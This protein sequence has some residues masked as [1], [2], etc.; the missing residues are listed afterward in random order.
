MLFDRQPEL[1]P[2]ISRA[3]VQSLHYEPALELAKTDPDVSLRFVWQLA[4]D[5][6]RLHKW[7]IALGRG[8]AVERI[9]TLMLDFRGRLMQAGLVNGDDF[10]LPLTQEQIGDHLGLTVVHV[11]RTL[12]K[13]REEGVLTAASGRARIHD[14]EALASY[15]APMQDI[16]ERESK[17][18]GGGMPQASMSL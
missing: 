15:A 8:N 1:D 11:N 17:N 18:F 4:E 16:F 2:G 5:E 6:R 7:V 13:L 14:V 10:Q 3:T 12:K 9:A